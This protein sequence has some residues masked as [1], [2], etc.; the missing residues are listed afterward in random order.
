MAEGLLPGFFFDASYDKLLIR[1]LDDLMSAEGSIVKARLNYRS[2]PA[3]IS[4]FYL[5]RYTANDW[6]DPEVSSGLETL[7]QLN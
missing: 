5:L 2:G 4:F 3:I 6:N 1:E 7:V